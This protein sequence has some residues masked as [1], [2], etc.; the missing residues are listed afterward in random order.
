MSILK[1]CISNLERETITKVHNTIMEKL[2]YCYMLAANKRIFQYS[3]TVKH[4]KLN[5][6]IPLT[7]VIHS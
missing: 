5:S 6:R 1:K 2:Q 3:H 4:R 7:N